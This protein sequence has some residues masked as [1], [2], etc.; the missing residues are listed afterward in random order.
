M[1]VR[2]LYFYLILIFIHYYHCLFRLQSIVISKIII[3]LFLKH[4]NFTTKSMF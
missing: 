2:Q 4:F 1:L 3:D